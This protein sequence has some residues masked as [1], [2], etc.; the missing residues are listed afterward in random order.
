MFRFTEPKF[1]ESAPNSPYCF[2]CMQKPLLAF[3]F[4]LNMSLGLAQAVQAQT[5]AQ[6]ATQ[7]GTL[8]YKLKPTAAGRAQQPTIAPPLDAVLRTLGATKVEQ[9]FPHTLAPSPYQPGSVDLRRVYQV[10]FSPSM[11]LQKA[12]FALL[13][14]GAL[15]YVEPVYERELLRQPNDPLSDSTRADGQY[16][17]KTIQA[18]RAW[19]ITQGDTSMVI[20]VLDTGMLF[21]HEDMQGQIKY[22]YADPIDGIDNDNDGY[23]DNFRGWDFADKITT[24]PYGPPSTTD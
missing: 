12:R 1:T 5:V 4:V 19:D 6:A 15:E 13:Q 10:W 2:L 18:Y 22:N 23:I 8:I 3:L 21:S 17:L 9:K 11:S 14:T 20:G 16:Y 7:P 24:P